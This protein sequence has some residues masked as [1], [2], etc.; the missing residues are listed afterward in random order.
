LP[1]TVATFITFIALGFALAAAAAAALADGRRERPA[2]IL[3]SLS[4]RLLYTLH[5]DRRHYESFRRAR[6]A[7]VGA[8]THPK[9]NKKLW[10]HQKYNGPT[11]NTTVNFE[12]TKNTMDPPKI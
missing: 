2:D 8:V 12:P 9:Y 4:L 3:L 11:K 5:L 6:L 10:T 7:R 1:T